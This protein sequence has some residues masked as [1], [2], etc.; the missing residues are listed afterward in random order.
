MSRMDQLSPIVMFAYSRLKNTRQTVSSLLANKEA[1]GSDLIVYSDAPK[2]MSAE[3]AVRQVRDYLHSIEGFRSVTIVERESNY[4]LVRNI[5]SGVTETV[6]RHGR[7][8][9]LEDD[10]SVSPYFLKYMNEGLV[11]LE[12]RKDIASIHGYMYPHGRPLPEAFLVKG[13]DCWGW[14]TWK[15][16]WDLFNP[17]AAYLYREIVRQGREAEFDFNGSYP[18]LR[19]LKE[20]ADGTAGSWAICWYAS[21]FIRNMYTVYPGKSM[22]QLNSIMDEGE[23]NRAARGMLKFSV[24]LNEKGVDWD[25]AQLTQE[26]RDARKEFELFFRSLKSW[27]RKCL[28]TVKRLFNKA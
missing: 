3:E 28:D 20:Q 12:G 16:A 26:S 15:R 10:H 5:V 22:V 17:D 6:G 27:K 7:V 13:A 1:E 18:Y 2:N 21:A 4:G 11:R 25:K 8:I 24:A 23:H 19:M 9:V 14:A